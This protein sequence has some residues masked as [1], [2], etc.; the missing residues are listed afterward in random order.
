[1]LE[2]I[3]ELELKRQALRR[4]VSRIFYQDGDRYFGIALI[5]LGISLMIPGVAIA[6]PT[7]P[8]VAVGMAIIALV[9]ICTIVLAPIGLIVL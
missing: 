5:I 7:L 9:C 1:M 8:V 6:V 3:I 4:Q 2:L